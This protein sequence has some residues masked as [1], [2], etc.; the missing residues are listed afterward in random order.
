MI[1]R[2]VLLGRL[3]I[4]LRF[5]VLPSRDEYEAT[6]LAAGREVRRQRT[7]IAGQDGGRSDFIDLRC[8]ERRPYFAT[9]GMS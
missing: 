1:I 7:L 3:V 8:G 9:P 4:L 2:S 5:L 6:D